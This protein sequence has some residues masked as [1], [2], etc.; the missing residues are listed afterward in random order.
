MGVTL[1][2][3]QPKL[4]A[5]DDNGNDV[6][7]VKLDQA[8]VEIHDTDGDLVFIPLDAVPALIE[9]LQRIMGVEQ[10]NQQTTDQPKEYT[11][12]DT[13][14]VGVVNVKRNGHPGHE[15]DD[16]FR[17]NANRKEIRLMDEDTGLSIS[18]N[19]KT[20]PGIVEAVERVMQEVDK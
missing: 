7:E 13:P 16:R 9:A 12:A 5:V 15:F 17:V 11:I 1:K 18:F 8:R 3:P 10:R 20:W 19:R 4:Y 6:F 2:S 14:E